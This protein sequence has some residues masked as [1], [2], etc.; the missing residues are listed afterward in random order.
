MEGLELD[1]MAGGAAALEMAMSAALERGSKI[2]PCRNC[3]AP[4]LGVFVVNAVSRSI[5]VAD[6]YFISCMM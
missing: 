6:L 1:G 3:G 2:G 5:R 4:V